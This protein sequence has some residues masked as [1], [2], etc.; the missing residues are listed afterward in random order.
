MLLV[1]E[2]VLPRLSGYFI[3]SP[4]ILG[5]EVMIRQKVLL[6]ELQ[7]HLEFLVGCSVCAKQ[8]NETT[9]IW[10][11]IDHHC[12]GE[13]LLARVKGTPPHQG[14]RK[15][16]RRPIFPNPRRYEECHYYRPGIGCR[17]HNQCTLASSPEEA[18]V[19]TFERQNC[20]PRLW[21]KARV[22]KS[23]HCQNPKNQRTVEKIW[24]EFGGYFQEICKACFE[25]CPQRVTLRAPNLMCPEH[26]SSGSI[27]VHRTSEDQMVEIRPKPRRRRLLLE[28]CMVVSK[29][30]PCQ[31]GATNCIYAHSD[32]E[33]A[34]WEA[35]TMDYLFRPDLIQ[36]R[37]ESEGRAGT[38]GEDSADVSPVFPPQIELYCQTCHVTFSSKESLK[39]HCSSLEHIQRV[40]YD[41]GAL[42][43]YQPPTIGVSEFKLCPRQDMC[44]YK[45]GCAKA[46]S[47]GEL[48]EW[49]LR[50]QTVQMRED[51]AWKHGFFFSQ[52][53]LFH[54]YQDSGTDVLLRK[55]SVGDINMYCSQP[56]QCQEED[57]KSH[58]SWK[59]IIHSKNRQPL[60]CVALLKHHMGA[61]FFLVGPGLPPGQAY[62]QGS[63]FRVYGA[64][65]M[66]FHVEVHVECV[67]SGSYDQWVTF[68]FE[69][70]P[71]LV[72]KLRLQVA[73]EIL[74]TCVQNHDCLLEM[75]HWHSGN[76][77]VVPSVARTAE[78]VKLLAKYNVSSQELGYYKLMTAAQIPITQANY[79][80]RMHQF[81]FVEE[82]AQQQL[83]DRLNL[84]VHGTLI[85]KVQTLAMGMKFDIQGK[86]YVKGQIPCSLTP[87]T[88]HGFLLSRAINTAYISPIPSPDN[89]V[90]E[91]QV[92][93][94]ITSERN[95]WL[96]LPAHCW[97][98]LWLEIR[99]SQL[100]EIQFQIDRMVFGMW[101]QAIDALYDERVVIPNIPACSL[102]SLMLPTQE[103]SCNE[104]QKQAISYIT[105][106]ASEKTQV[107]PLLICGSF[108]TGKTYT[109]AW[110]SLEVIKQPN[111]KVLIC[112]YTNSA[113]DVY[114]R[115]YF[116]SY[117][118]AGHTEAV[119][120]RVK[121]SESLLHE[122]D[123]TTL[124]YCC[125][126]EDGS[127]FRF[128][129]QD[130]L[131]QHPIIVTTTTLSHNLRVPPGFFSHILIDE[132]DQMLEWEAIM[133]LA[134][135]TQGTR[136]AL[137]GDHLQRTPT[138]FNVR[139]RKSADYSLFNRL[140]QY[141]EQETHKL[142]SQC[143]I[144]F[145]K[146]YRT[147]K[148][149]IPF[150]L[151]N[152]YGSSKIHVED[153]GIPEHP[154]QYPLMLCY[155]P[156]T[157]ERDISMTSWL[158]KAEIVGV[159]KRVQE[160]YHGWV[161]QWGSPDQK[162]ICV[163]SS[164]SQVQR[165]REELRKKQLGEV[166]VENAENVPGREFRVVIISTVHTQDSLLSNSAT[167]LEFFNE[168]QLLNTV[169]TR[170]QS[171]LVVVGDPM[172]LCSFGHC[173]EIWKD[174]IL[175][176]FEQGNVFPAF[177]KKTDVEQSSLLCLAWQNRLISGA[178]AR[179][180]FLKEEE[181]NHNVTT[182]LGV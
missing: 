86:V 100:L 43:E 153:S 112:T 51:L 3:A 96:L 124:Q 17:R 137:A 149:I 135:A 84:Q 53:W 111:T 74:P 13:I 76:R 127:S 105:G 134:Y 42:W 77:C 131:E 110:A 128:P 71:L 11:I 33:M 165:L 108:G 38:S 19:W 99:D 89:R 48:Q 7:N 14:W 20:I 39:K 141:Y 180:D 122:T 93:A 37:I 45:D 119:P 132:A 8:M 49:I 143:K 85:S 90:Y 62:A 136:I 80:D 32:V 182:S 73:P 87:D 101:H 64:A 125:L 156:G 56:L 129:T 92:K 67:T 177:L 145:H 178:A 148:A 88:D 58:C 103:I 47:L 150:L 104:K 139:D 25:S 10:Q 6:K 31:Y 24:A 142:A 59:F 95:V 164:G 9:Y 27:L 106:T 22:Q 102:P 46:H 152:F 82:E 130:E 35:E 61:V 29:G 65:V 123:L 121:H 167:H 179:E 162:Q 161:C 169:M 147:T 168:P 116:H 155:M 52:D 18:L 21:L 146:N 159:I 40:S 2:G 1:P 63:R 109:L 57:K 75:T 151:H 98:S 68:A 140:F 66:T 16:R 54:E 181:D 41:K 36:A 26:L 163:V 55:R 72:Q 157:P 166:V 97:S 30:K 50:A 70:G 138:L 5:Q 79:R 60:R 175:K 133:P 118:T 81:L 107:P 91:I 154:W 78:Q 28:Y 115:E 23:W 34:V 173:K 44:P 117:A 4:T 144:I 176:T 171:Q 170:A 12:S 158:N 172:A 114:I 83:V 160:F 120:L 113:A 126:S 94:N 69:R 15:V 174:F